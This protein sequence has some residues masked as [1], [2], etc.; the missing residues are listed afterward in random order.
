VARAAW[1]LGA[2]FQDRV[3]AV[4][5]QV[6]NDKPR[7]VVLAAREELARHVRLQRLV[8]VQ[9]DGVVQVRGRPWMRGVRGIYHHDTAVLLQRIINR[10]VVG[11]VIQVRRSPLRFRSLTLEL[12]HEFQIAVVAA[13]GIA[14]K[15][16]VRCGLTLQSAFGPIPRTTMGFGHRSRKWDRISIRT[17][18]PDAGTVG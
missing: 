16:L 14:A 10:I 2:A 7:P 18:I 4:G 12:S 11:A 3:G 5:G 1:Q 15:T 6:I 8:R 13:F 17:L 9:H